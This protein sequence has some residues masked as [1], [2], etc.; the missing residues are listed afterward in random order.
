[1]ITASQIVHLRT[2]SDDFEETERLKAEFT[3][4]REE[5][6]PFYLTLEEFDRILRW[7]LRGHYP[8]QRVLRTANTDDVVRAVTRCV[9][10]LSLDDK[11]Y[12]LE[13]RIN[14]LR[15]LRGVEIPVASAVLALVLPDE[16]AVINFRNW[17]QVFGEERRTFSLSDYKSYLE[18]IR[19]LA[20]EL[21]WRVQEVDLAIWEYDK[22][23]PPAQR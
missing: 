16:Y 9:F 11:E 3:K 19:P 10:A 1:M 7:T 17:R 12:E 13:L 22:R 21:G 5:R 14:L 8:R 18:K 15:A 4:L 23:H 2:A 6:K 20:R